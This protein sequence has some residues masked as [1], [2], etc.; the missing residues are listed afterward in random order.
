MHISSC[1]STHKVT[2][3]QSSQLI[4]SNLQLAF[5]TL[6]SDCAK[7]FIKKKQQKFNH[8]KKSERLLRIRQVALLIYGW[9]CLFS[10]FFSLLLLSATNSHTVECIVFLLLLFLLLCVQYISDVSHYVC[11][12]AVC[13]RSRTSNQFADI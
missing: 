5:L 8:T 2:H 13:V 7:S 4:Y 9:P 12:C 11:G 6:N 3:I 1:L 10:V